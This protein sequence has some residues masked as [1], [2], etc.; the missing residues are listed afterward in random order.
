MTQKNLE[1]IYILRFINTGHTVC[2][3]LLANDMSN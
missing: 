2:M 3:H 1:Q